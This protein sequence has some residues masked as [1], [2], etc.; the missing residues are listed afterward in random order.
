MDALINKIKSPLKLSTKTEFVP[1]LIIFAAVIFSA[2]TYN[3][4]PE[5]VASHWNINSQPDGWSSRNFHAIFFP[6]LL[7]ALYLIFNLIPNLDP[8]KERY[9]ELTKPYLIFRNLIIFVLAII[10]VAATLSNLAWPINIGA[11]AAGSIGLLMIVLGNYLGKIKRNWFVGVRNPW[12][13]SSE[14]VWNK[15][16][17][18]AGK[19]FIICGILLAIT[20]WLKPSFTIIAIL[21]GA[22]ILLIFVNVFSY[23]EYK[24]EKKK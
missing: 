23:F 17:R 9:Q 5:T 13:L 19:I 21:G 18:V 4:L 7:F 24:K 22:G 20:P 3:L 6:G 1:L 12:T 11:I 8:K 14:N 10:F 2:L 16:H 15:T